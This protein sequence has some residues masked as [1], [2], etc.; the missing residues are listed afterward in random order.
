MQTFEST[1]A[2]HELSSDM[3][4]DFV[5]WLA[6]SAYFVGSTVTLTAAGEGYALLLRWVASRFPTL[7][8]SLGIL[9]YLT[10]AIT[11]VLSLAGLQWIDQ[12]GTSFNEFEREVG[13]LAWL[14]S[15][16]I[17]VAFFRSRHSS[18]LHKLGYFQSRK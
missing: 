2:C 1:A 15:M 11:F 13:L 7:R 14:L 10:F 16:L 4:G 5:F 3:K 17:A 18:V 9:L 12:Q 6:I 8:L